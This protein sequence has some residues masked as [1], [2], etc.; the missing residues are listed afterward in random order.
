MKNI[1]KIISFIGLALTI[2]PSFLVFAGVVTLEIC[3]I[4]MFI[5]SII[6]FAFAPG[7]MNEPNPKS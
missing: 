4:L 5:G 1:I 7:W 3:K 6:W 2:I